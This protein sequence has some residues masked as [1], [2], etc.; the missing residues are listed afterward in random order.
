MASTDAAS[1]IEDG[2]LQMLLGGIS[3][4]CINR[5]DGFLAAAAVND[6]SAAVVIHVAAACVGPQLRRDTGSFELGSHCPGPCS[7]QMRC[8]RRCRPVLTL[9]PT[10]PKIGTDVVG[11]EFNIT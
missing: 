1:L 6:I 11:I 8:G 5:V 2:V 10:K 7:R 9:Y 3:H 4:L